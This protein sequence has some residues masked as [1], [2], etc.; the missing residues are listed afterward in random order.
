MHCNGL[1]ERIIIIITIW[2]A[3]YFEAALLPSSFY[4]L[5]H[6]K[7]ILIVFCT[8]N[9]YYVLAGDLP[10]LHIP[11]AA[12]RLSNSTRYCN[13][14]RTRFR[15]LAPC[16]QLLVPIAVPIVS[17]KK[18]GSTEITLLLLLTTSFFLTTAGHC[19]AKRRQHGE[20]NT[21]SWLCTRTTVFNFSTETVI[22]GFHDEAERSIIT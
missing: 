17:L 6:K 3:S 16:F 15:L 12:L 5:S 21:D 18:K 4:S 13:F 19:A 20:L 10:Y 8:Y 1:N 22:R 11:L 7:I 9:Y 2:I 14:L